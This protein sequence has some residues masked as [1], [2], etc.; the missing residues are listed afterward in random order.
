[1]TVLIYAGQSKAEIEKQDTQV[2]IET[3]EIESLQ[4]F[5]D[6]FG[7]RKLVVAM[8]SGAEYMVDEWSMDRVAKCFIESG[9]AGRP[10]IR[11]D[12]IAARFEEG[13]KPS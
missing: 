7:R 8:K 2:L 3:N 10:S 5:N 6:A 12:P 4:A 13:D 9:A 11:F 1:M